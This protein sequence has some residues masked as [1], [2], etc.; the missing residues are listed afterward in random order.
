[1]V[2]TYLFKWCLY[3]TTRNEGMPES[4][5]NWEREWKKERQGEKERDIVWETPKVHTIIL[6]MLAYG[7]L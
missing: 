1:M 4:K 5:S 2:S 3:T 7:F 6:H